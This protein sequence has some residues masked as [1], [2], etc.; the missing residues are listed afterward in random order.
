MAVRK[1]EVITFKVDE[2]LARALEG[3]PNRSEFIRSSILNALENTCPLCKGVG[4]L[5]PNQKNHWEEF[6][7]RH[8]V[9]E[10]SEC[11]EL[12]ITC[13]AGEGINIHH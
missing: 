1:G 9:E 8:S 13:H 2:S 4:I 12:H 6:A 3:I 11:H 5:T 7:L 10:C